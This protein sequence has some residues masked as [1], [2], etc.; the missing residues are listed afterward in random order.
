[1]K[2]QEYEYMN[3]LENSH[4]W[5]IAKKKFLVFSLNKFV[6]G[7]KL[8]VLDVGCGTGAILQ[9]LEDQGYDATGIDFSEIAVDYCQDKKLNVLKGSAEKLI[10]SDSTFDVIVAMDLLEHLKNDLVAVEEFRRVLKPGGLAIIAVPAHPSLFSIHDE[11]LQ[12][13]RR[14]GRKQ[15]LDLFNHGW[16]VEKI[17]W[18]HGLI[19]LPIMFKRFLAKVGFIK[20]QSSDVRPVG[21]ITEVVLNVLYKVELF[22]YKIFGRLPFGLSLLLVVRKNSHRK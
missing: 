6:R 22:Y 4:P 3:R 19:L 1:M 2:K 15:F 7:Q 5:F 16:T 13:Y 8:K 21:K 18:I 9:L 10:F 12:H 20:G 17:S 14:Y 11:E